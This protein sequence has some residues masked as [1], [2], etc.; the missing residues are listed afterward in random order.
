MVDILCAK[1]SIK[2]VKCVCCG[3]PMKTASNFN[4]NHAKCSERMADRLSETTRLEAC[5]QKRRINDAV[6]D[7]LNKNAKRALDGEGSQGLPK[8]RRKDAHTTSALQ[9]SRQS[10][11]ETYISGL[12]HALYFS[13]RMLINSSE[14]GFLF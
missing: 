14:L 4:K 8:K 2:D 10:D 12:H 6:K 11:S 3:K 1:I 5:Q 13:I 9:I 7:S